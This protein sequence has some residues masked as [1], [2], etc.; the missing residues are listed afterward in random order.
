MDSVN[1]RNKKG[2]KPNRSRPPSTF[3]RSKKLLLKT[4]F[5]IWTSS[6]RKTKTK[7]QISM[8]IKELPPK[9]NFQKQRKMQTLKDQK[10]WIKVSKRTNAS[11]ARLVIRWTT[12]YKSTA[13]TI[14]I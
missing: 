14:Q 11:N 1:L 2:K 7:I 3:S 12:N 6:K 4:I 8:K 10:I 5:S 13:L 9:R